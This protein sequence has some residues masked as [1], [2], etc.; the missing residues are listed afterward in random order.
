MYRVVV[1]KSI[2]GYVADSPVVECFCFEQAKSEYRNA[3]ESI[4]IQFTSDKLP[5][6]GGS[7]Y[8]A[9]IADYIGLVCDASIKR[10]SDS[11]E[12]FVH[13]SNENIDN[14]IIEDVGICPELEEKF[15]TE[16]PQSI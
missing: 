6:E 14:C 13:E 16:A 4:K 8:I 11:S 15:K 1:T 7:A 2:G 3:V 12:M 9:L 5:L 10:N